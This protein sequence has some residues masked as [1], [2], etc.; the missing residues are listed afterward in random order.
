MTLNVDGIYTVVDP[1][2][3]GDDASAVETPRIA[4]S[5]GTWRWAPQDDL[6]SATSTTSGTEEMCLF[7]LMYRE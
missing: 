6:P 3:G 2:L 4:A 5:I 7:F 1:L